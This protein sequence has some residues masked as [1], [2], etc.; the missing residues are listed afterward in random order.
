[1]RVDHL[2]EEVINQFL[3]ASEQLLER[4]GI[5]ARSQVDQILIVWLGSDYRSLA[6]SRVI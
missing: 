2:K 4:S 3:V 6:H 5:T 1:M